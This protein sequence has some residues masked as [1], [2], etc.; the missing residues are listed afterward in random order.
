MKFYILFPL[1]FCHIVFIICNYYMI[2]NYSSKYI[3][4]VCLEDNNGEQNKAPTHGVY[5]LQEMGRR[6]VSVYQINPE[7]KLY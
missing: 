2:F 1:T 7:I 6:K 5:C 3:F 4:I